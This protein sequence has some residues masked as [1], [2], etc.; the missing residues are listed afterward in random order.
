MI[1]VLNMLEWKGLK[2]TKQGEI[3]ET[4]ETMVRDKN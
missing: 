4:G 1:F 2:G 3:Q